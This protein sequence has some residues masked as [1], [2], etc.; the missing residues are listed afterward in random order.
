MSDSVRYSLADVAKCN[1]KNETRTWIVIHDKV[2]DV[3]DYMQQHP[4]GSEL[5]EE[6]AGKD[7]TD[8]FDDFGH[9]SDATK[10][11]KK[12]L[13]GDLEN[14]DKHANRKKKQAVSNN[15]ITSEGTKKPKQKTFLRILCG[16]CT[17]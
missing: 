8:G 17:H 15:G 12:Y 7:A 13:I 14:E 9:S 5:I 4:G 3:T 10:I 16:K 2:Y 1:G 6:Y 11:L